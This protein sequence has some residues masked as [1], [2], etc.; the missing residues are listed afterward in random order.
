MVAIDHNAGEAKEN[1]EDAEKNIE[2]AEQHQKS[3]GKCMCY[4]VSIIAGFAAVVIVI[5]VISLT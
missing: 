5:L 1:A 4:S 2:E 3:A